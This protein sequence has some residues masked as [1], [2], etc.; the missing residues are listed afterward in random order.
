VEL[1]M[2][3]IKGE[4]DVGTDTG[5]VLNEFEMFYIKQEDSCTVKSEF[6]VSCHVPS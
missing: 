1:D 4:P 5:P 3:M 6:K 2:D